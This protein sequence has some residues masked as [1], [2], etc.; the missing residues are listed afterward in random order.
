MLSRE[1]DELTENFASAQI[2]NPTLEDEILKSNADDAEKAVLD[3][4]GAL[5]D[6]LTL[7]RPRTARDVLILSLRALAPLQEVVT[8][9]PEEHAYER[10]QGD[11]AFKLLG[12]MVPA[13]EELA[14]VTRAELGFHEEYYSRI[15]PQTEIEIMEK[16]KAALAQRKPGGSS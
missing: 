3:R 8:A 16:L 10:K 15:E 13:L 1:L 5:A 9:V 11:I 4:M 2:D 7:E 12:R 14:G 6:V